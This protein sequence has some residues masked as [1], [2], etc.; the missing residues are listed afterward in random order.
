MTEQTTNNPGSFFETLVTWIKSLPTD[1][2]ILIEMVGDDNLDMSARTLAAGVLVYIMAPID[3]I[4]DSVPVLGYVDD[5]VVLHIAVA[6]ILQLDQERTEFYREKYVEA[7]GAIDEQMELVMRA[8][9]ALYS[10][11]LAFVENL[12]QRRYKG[13]SSEET[14]RSEKAREDILDDAMIFAAKIN[15]DEETIR[16]KLLAAPPNQITKLLSDG[17]EQEQKRQ[18]KT[19]RKGI[20]GIL[21]WS[22]TAKAE[23]SDGGQNS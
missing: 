16:Q 20:G 17:L 12:R 8:L 15:L 9:G 11:L 13:K 1:L 10:W 14:V 18:P 23:L 5:V 6:A 4:P 7:I 3:L 22:K 19:K 21:P 2:K